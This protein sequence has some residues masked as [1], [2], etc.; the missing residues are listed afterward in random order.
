[1]IVRITG[2]GLYE[3]EPSL[4]DQLFALDV[5]LDAAVGS[6]SE[7]AFNSALVAIIRIVRD[8]GQNVEDGLVPSADLVLPHPSATLQ[9]WRI[10][11]DSEAFEC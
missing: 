3:I 10:L 5:S 4:V 6:G 2:E 8:Q 11:L 7:S 1:M 9:E